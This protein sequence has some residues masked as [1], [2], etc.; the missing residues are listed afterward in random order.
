MPT[1]RFAIQHGQALDEARGRLEAAVVEA[2][3]RF[4]PLI[5]RIDWSDD[6]RSVTLEGSGFRVD[7]RVDPSELHVEGD[8]G[9]LGSLAGNPLVVGL[10]QV[11]QNAFKTQLPP[12]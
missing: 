4:G 6:R 5:R 8:V 10:K 7:L 3:G 2:S 11:L 9:L 12:P 1:F